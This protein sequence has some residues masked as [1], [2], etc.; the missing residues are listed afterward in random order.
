MATISWVH[1]VF[2][3][4]DRGNVSYF[5]KKLDRICGWL[6]VAD[7][8]WTDAKRR[9]TNTK[10][11]LFPWQWT[12]W[13]PQEGL[14]LQMIRGISKGVLK[15]LKNAQKML[16]E[17]EHYVTAYFVIQAVDV[18]RSSTTL[19]TMEQ[20]YGKNSFYWHWWLLGICF[21]SSLSDRV[22]HGVD[23]IHPVLF[24]DTFFDTRLNKFAAASSA[25]QQE[26]KQKVWKPALPWSQH[27]QKVST[28]RKSA[29]T[30]LITSW[31]S[32]HNQ[33]QEP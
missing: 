11:P 17:G 29:V 31:K 5:T 26:Q 32:H 19:R 16:L 24:N 6:R 20:G 13:W 23:S 1:F 10:N 7:R 9:L 22:L 14:S 4:M 8:W 25:L 15:P 12:A 18:S 21:W 28:T 27:Y 2:S 3:M 30:F 33:A